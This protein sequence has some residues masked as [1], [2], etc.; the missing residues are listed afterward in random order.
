[1]LML[2]TKEAGKQVAFKYKKGDNTDN[3]VQVT[4]NEF[5]ADTENLGA[6]LTQD[7][8]CASHIAC[9]GENSYKWIV[10]YLTVLKSAGVFVPI[11]KELPAAD[12]INIINESESNVVF[13]AKKHEE[14]LK[15]NKDKMPLVKCFIG[16]E[17]DD[18]EVL[19]KSY[20]RYIEY[21]KTC[22]KDKYDIAENNSESLKLL[23]YTSGTTGISK[24]V[25]LSERNLVSSVYYGMQVSRVYDTCLSVL[26]YHHTYESVSG[27]LVSLHNHSTICIN[28]SLKNVLKNLQLYKPSYI[29][30]VPAFAE[31]FYSNIIKT[32]KKQGKEKAFNKLIKVSNRLRKVGI[33]MRKVFF[34]KI[35]A[36]FGGRLIKIVT[37]GAPIRAEI[38]KFFDDIGINLING[39][40]I[41]ECSPLVS[42]NNDFFNDW[43]TAGIKLPCIEWRIDSPN[44]EGIGEI[45][46]KGDIVMMG[47][48]KQPEKT[49]EVLKDGWFYTGDYGYLNKYD[50]L[51]ITGRKKNI[52][53]LNNGKNIYPEEIE[54]YIQGIEYVTE[55]IVRGIKNEYGHDASL[56][57]EVFLS[58]EK[59][60]KDVLA[61]IREVLKDLPSYKSISKVVIRTEEFP[62]TTSKKIKR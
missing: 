21:G 35:H 12:I 40:G 26:P 27:I 54:S 36:N 1:M 50:Q 10:T 20:D 53:V 15:A 28:D 56:L 24:G 3:I 5:S 33:D 19:F 32:I 57:A 39:Y 43:N 18:D 17:K 37:G 9:I 23:V 4:Y 30:L 61:D 48:Y 14:V 41:T 16:F 25:M 46:V 55:V 47:Y 60:E 49:A 11:D 29:Y 8:F 44:S 7:G 31:V 45:C 51:V 6:A 2:A 62:K 13:Y 38:G 22:D 58:E 34:K 42:A 52:I 59:T